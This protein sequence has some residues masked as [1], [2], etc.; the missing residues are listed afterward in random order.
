MIIISD[1]KPDIIIRG[2]AGFA[3][4]GKDIVCA[5]VSMLVQNLVYSL[6]KLTTAEFDTSY[7]KGYTAICF[8]R[9]LPKDAQ[10][11]VDSF[12]CGID[13]LAANYPDNVKIDRAFKS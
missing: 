11:L 13:L 12:F 9:D 7:S 4:S 6:S 1:N 2:H 5:A 8:L 10:L 3:E